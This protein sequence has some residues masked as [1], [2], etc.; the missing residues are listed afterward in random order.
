MWRML[1]VTHKKTDALTARAEA[2][3]NG[4]I[5]ALSDAVRAEQHFGHRVEC[6][7]DVDQRWRTVVDAIKAM[8]RPKGAA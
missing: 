2:A 3:R 5:R 1:L 8:G 4:L 7:A 6:R